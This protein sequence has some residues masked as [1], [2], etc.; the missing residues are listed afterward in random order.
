MY[1]KELKI[2][3]LY[4]QLWYKSENKAFKEYC[5]HDF[6]QKKEKINHLY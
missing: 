6:L 3:I 5:T 4:R 1:E 2:L